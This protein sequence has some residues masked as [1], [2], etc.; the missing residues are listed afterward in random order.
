MGRYMRKAKITG[1]VVVMEV[2]HQSSWGVRTRA[3]TLALQRDASPPPAPA[4]TAP[5]TDSG[6]YIQLRSR[7]LEKPLAVP[8]RTTGTRE[9][10]PRAGAT[11]KAPQPK[12][13]RR[14]AASV[15]SGPVSGPASKGG[16]REGGREEQFSETSL[17]NDDVEASFG[18]NV[19]ESEASDSRNVRETTPCSLIRDS[20]STGTPGSSTRSR[21]TSSRRAQIISCR[22]LPTT[23]EMEGFFVGPE[24]LQQRTF[25]EKYAVTHLYFP[26]SFPLILYNFD[27]VN[28]CPLPGRYDW[29]KLHS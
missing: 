11:A 20:E 5:G 14:G 29:V 13:P 10:G 15:N 28:D 3:R 8:S 2:S 4:P 18:E 17:G 16:S 22:N 12:S 21:P 6:S 25:I 9:G 26:Y 27:P 7:R 19:L 1:E 24:Q 23:D